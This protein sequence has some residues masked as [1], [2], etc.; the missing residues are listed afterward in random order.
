MRAMFGLGSRRMR[1]WFALGLCCGFAA[2]SAA[3]ASESTVATNDADL[4][5]LTQES[6]ALLRDNRAAD[7]YQRLSAHELEWSGSPAFDYLLGVAAL[8]SG[9]P[10][11]AIFALERAVA[12][13]PEFLGARMELA[14][15]Y[16]DSGEDAESRAQF[17]FLQTQ[18]APARASA[19]IDR[20][21]AAL[22]ARESLAAARWS[23]AVQFGAGYDT[24]ANGSTS[25][26]Q[27]LG[28]TLDPRNVE[29][30]SGF[31]E[32]GA[33]VGL[34]VPTSAR[35]GLTTQFQLTHR[36]NPD[37]SYVDQSVAS[38]GTTALWQ[39]S[40][41]RLSAGV[42][43]AR[44]WLDGEAHDVALNLDLGASWRFAGDWEFGLSGRAGT[45]RYDDDR[46]EVLDTKRFLLGAALTRANLGDVSGRVGVALL[47]GRDDARL[48]TS[49][50]DNDR[51]G[52]RAHAGWLLAPQASVYLEASLLRA[53]YDAGSFFGSDR[54][55]EQYG[56][57]LALEFQNWPA[58][59]WIVS[60]RVRWMR[61]D[62]TVALYEYDRVEAA[63][64]VRRNF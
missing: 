41:T 10:R 5:A 15:A 62:S 39:A 60:P 34:A 29:T 57:T 23:S 28:F 24:N 48:D 40:N 13:Q 32:L 31:A 52:V 36:A 3:P 27:F 64:F 19:V 61:N 22:D 35:S 37:A 21:I 14:R 20:Y 47:G 42:N 51:R 30:D 7:A 58:H 63:L 43:G 11:D 44:A 12:A 55:D 1:R 53:E 59:Q 6:E 4:V 8:D 17:E 33:F 2:L 46:L 49:A 38:L 56:A 54:V 25:A 50:Y 9:K 45:V 16:F 18:G 26:S